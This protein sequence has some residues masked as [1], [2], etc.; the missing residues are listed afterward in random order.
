[1]ALQELP[2]LDALMSGVPYWKNGV[3]V[4]DYKVGAQ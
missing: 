2:V 3:T 1:M 4:T